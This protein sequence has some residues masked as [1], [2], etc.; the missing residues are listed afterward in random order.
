MSNEDRLIEALGPSFDGAEREVDE[1]LIDEIVGAMS[2]IASPALTGKMS[3]GQSFEANFEGLDGL[4]EAW[5][6]WL[7]TFARVRFEID[8]MQAVGENVVTFARQY[9]VTHHSE[10]PIEQPSAA[11]WKFRDGCLV[12]IEFHLDRERA[13]ESARQP[14]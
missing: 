3:G 4:R 10:V 11:V 9:G 12:R 8:E 13:L 6:D 14:A 5:S 2:A 7:A 1:A